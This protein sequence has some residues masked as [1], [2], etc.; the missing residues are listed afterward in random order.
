MVSSW[1]KQGTWLIFKFCRGSSG[2]ITQ[3]VY[4][5]RGKWPWLNNVSGVYLIQDS[6]LTIVK[7]GLIDFC[8]YR[9]LLPIGWRSVPIL[10]QRRRKTTNT[11][12]TTLSATQASSQ[13]P[14]INYTP[15]VISRSD[16]NKQLT[17]LSQRKLAIT[18]VK[19][20]LRYKIIGDLNNLKTS[21]V[22]Q[23]GLVL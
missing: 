2:F 14:F 1:P 16:K 5:S 20:F 23:L 18:A 17:L 9:F 3:K 10:R 11:A 8:R 15:L 7:Q 13:S 6:F 12:P 19:N 22:P 21:R 4:I